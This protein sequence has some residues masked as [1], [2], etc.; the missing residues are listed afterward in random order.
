MNNADAIKAIDASVAALSAVM[1]LTM[2]TR[3]VSDII[4]AR[5][6][7]GGRPWSEAELQLV[8]SELLK[9]RQYALEQIN[10]AAQDPPEG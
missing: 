4:A 3:T 5:L 10:L 2:A 9:S 6:A 8:E 1:N 7:D